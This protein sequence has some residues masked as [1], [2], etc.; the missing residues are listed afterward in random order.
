MS[1][2]SRLF[3][4]SYDPAQ[5]VQPEPYEPFMSTGGIPVVDPGSPLELMLGERSQV[6]TFWRTQPNL[7]KV[8][9]FIARNVAS[10]PLHVFERV[11][12]TDRRR[13]TDHVLARTLGAPQ[14]RVNPFRFWHGVL[15]DGLLYD[16]WCVLKVA[17]PD[18]GLDLVQVPSWRLKIEVDPLRRVVGLWYWMGDR[19]DDGSDWESIPLE[20]AI[21][22]HG[23]AP[24]TAGLTPVRTLRDILDESAEAVSYRRDVWK[25]GARMPGYV[26]RPKEA[27]AWTEE[28]RNRFVAAMRSV[29]GKDGSNAGGMPVFED[30]MEIK[31]SDVFSPQDANDLEGRRLSAIEVAAAYHI[32]PE[33]VGAQQGNY[34]NIDAFRQMMYGPSL[35][36]YISAWEGVLN[37]QL[38]P[39]FTEGRSLYIEANVEAKL[40]GS[41]E[42]QATIM[43]SA[44]GA[45][46]LTRNEA[47][48]KQNLPPVD[49]GD[50]LVVPLNV[51]TG[52]Q[53]S[54]R[55]SGSQNVGKS[56]V[57]FDAGGHLP[58]GLNRVRNSSGSPMRLR[59]KD[60]PARHEDK[61]LEV[62]VSFFKRQ[63]AAVSSALGAGDDDWWD[64]ER[65]DSELSDDLLRLSLLTSETA[66]K[67]AL[68]A[69]GLDPAAYD[70]DRTLAYLRKAADV[71]AANINALTLANVQTAV[72]AGEPVADVFDDAAGQRADAAAVSLTSFAAGF[73]AVEG[74]RQQS[75]GASKTWRV[76]SSNPRSS[77]AAMDGETVPL[78][79]TFSNGLMWPGALGDPDE[80]AGC[81]CELDINIP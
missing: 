23:Y 2:W 3:G 18:G 30:G 64:G 60:R 75:S 12:D 72:A 73:G 27:G 68:D 58:R 36:P 5:R 81:Q 32:A 13:V 44:T 7:R 65:W 76:T 15:S 6:E 39:D 67:A 4:G 55:D 40:R 48:A 79:E 43:Q 51:L 37:T 42:E 10:T 71:N 56:G 22:D 52:G 1:I 77:H 26:A 41:F 16:R 54:P 38:T 28:Q 14:P 33:L 21:F 17:R 66:A 53:A 70:V 20:E 34:S 8:V 57:H 74:A 47:R 19:T 63:G 29:Y 46:W 78:D 9:D 24:R 11:S 69:A 49:G 25:N 59:Q 45:P 62:L 31:T 35:G 80:V 50:E 61:A